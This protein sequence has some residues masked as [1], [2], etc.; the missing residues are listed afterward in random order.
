V[1]DTSPRLRIGPG[2]AHVWR[3]SLDP[4]PEDLE[5]FE[6]TLS[7]DEV[8]RADRFRGPGLRRRFVAGRGGLRAVLSA[9][10]GG[11]AEAVA[12]SYGRHGKPTLEP[13]TE[14]PPFEFNL[15][16]THELA[17]C[18][19]SSVGRLGVDVE[20]LRPMDGDGRGLIGR[21]FSASEQAEFLSLADHDRL[22]AFFRGWTR[23]EAYLK[24]VGT[25]L[26]TVLDSFDVTLAPHLPA[27]ILRVGDDLDAGERWS[28][29]DLDAGPGYAAA[30]AIEA[31]GRAVRVTTRELGAL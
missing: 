13:E 17:L 24:A 19:I 3:Y 16:H 29:F 21:Y 10:L 8:R 4:S 9:Y 18:A 31:H 30:L 12:F 28:L 22:S 26:A 14:A 15:S 25:G 1:A 5:R 20:Q 23:K 2:E 6:A 7:A 11:P 27:A